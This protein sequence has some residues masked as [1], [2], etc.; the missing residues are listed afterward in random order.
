MVDKRF[1]IIFLFMFAFTGGISYLVW[2]VFLIEKKI[3][4]EEID[5]ESCS[6][7]EVDFYLPVNAFLKRCAASDKLSYVRRLFVNQ[8]IS[9]NQKDLAT[10][11]MYA[12]GAT[13]YE[14]MKKAFMNAIDKEPSKTAAAKFIKSSLEIIDKDPTLIEHI[15]KSLKEGYSQPILRLRGDMMKPDIEDKDYKKF[16]N[17]YKKEL[18]KWIDEK[19]GS[20]LDEI[21]EKL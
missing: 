13:T 16:K 7:K 9:S 19:H 15:D 12:Q 11:I 8:W 5:I 21:I 14:D 6:Y 17:D 20:L 10:L 4:T 18:K 1:F 3:E 2:R